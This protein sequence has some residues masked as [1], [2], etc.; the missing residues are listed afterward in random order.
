MCDVCVRACRSGALCVAHGLAD[1]GEASILAI[2][3]DTGY[4][5]GVGAVSVVNAYYGRDHV[6]LGAYVG[7]VGDPAHTPSTTQEWTNQARGW[8]VQDLLDRFPSRVRDASAVPAAVAVLRRALADAPDGSVTFVAI[9]HA[10]NLHALLS[11]EGTCPS[12]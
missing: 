2:T 7:D 9:G 4:S 6:P 5:A 12:H 3:H 1:R 8:Y 11:S 10:T